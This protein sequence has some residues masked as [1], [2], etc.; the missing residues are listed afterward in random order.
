MQEMFGVLETIPAG[1]PGAGQVVKKST[2]RYTKQEFSDYI[3]Q[4][5]SWGA[6]EG[7]WFD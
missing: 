4:V 5:W 3:E 2:T 1:L 7:F 6:S